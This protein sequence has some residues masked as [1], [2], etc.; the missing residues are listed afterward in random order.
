MIYHVNGTLANKEKGFV[1][2]DVNGIGYKVN[3]PTNIE[4]RLPA[5][6]SKIKLFTYQVVRED[7]HL[8]FGFL[9]KEERSLFAL[10]ITVSGVGPKAALSVMSA[11]AIETITGAIVKGKAEVLSSAPGVGKKTALKICIELKEK[12][13]KTLGVN[14]SQMQQALPE[15]NG[16]VNDAIQALLALGYSPKE[17]RDAV[18]NSGIDFEKAPNAEAIIKGSLK[19]LV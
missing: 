2:I 4:T 17:A 7:A 3:I 19:A 15:E 13:A 12:L 6:G 11:F 14:P 18:F 10:L 5:N 1:V 8:L 9:N 16:M